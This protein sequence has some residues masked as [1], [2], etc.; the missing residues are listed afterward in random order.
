MVRD[1]I[2]RLIEYLD[3][4]H[5]PVIAASQGNK[6]TPAQVVGKELQDAG[7]GGGECVSEHRTLQSD[8]LQIRLKYIIMGK[9]LQ[10]RKPIQFKR[11]G[12][13]A[14]DYISALLS[15]LRAITI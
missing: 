10:S 6:G 7:R 3:Q 15:T 9:I 1:D 13:R 4:F 12:G 11:Q 8:L 5:D 2:V 14:E